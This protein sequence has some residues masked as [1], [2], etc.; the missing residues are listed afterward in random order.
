MPEVCH[1]LDDIF[2]GNLSDVFCLRVNNPENKCFIYLISPWIHDLAMSEEYIETFISNLFQLNNVDYSKLKN[3]SSILKFL[4]LKVPFPEKID[5]KI[6]TSEYNSTKIK[7]DNHYLNLRER[8]FLKKILDFGGEVYLHPDLHSK[9]ILTQGKIMDGSANITFPGFFTHTENVSLYYC[10]D[11]NYS[12]KLKRANDIL[13]EAKAYKS[14][15]DVKN[16]FK[17]I[18]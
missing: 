7:K 18:K 12:D 4:K 6:I 5:I 15:D 14:L 10:G 2:F 9:M 3:V 1:Q 11:D 17:N 16:D 13:D 8:R